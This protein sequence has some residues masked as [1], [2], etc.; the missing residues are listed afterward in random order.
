MSK[1]LVSR[2][3]RW[4]AWRNMMVAGINAGLELKL[5]GLEKGANH[6]PAEIIDGRREPFVF[7]FTFPGEI[8]AIASVEDA[9]WDELSIHVAL[10]PKKNADHL[11][12]AWNASLRVGNAFAAGWLERRKGRWLQTADSPHFFNCRWPLQSHLSS[13]TIKPRGFVDHGPL[14]L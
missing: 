9:G 10:E 2:S 5:F 6:W 11:I 7:R 13:L 3:K 4:L 14:M 1:A 8:E 12:V